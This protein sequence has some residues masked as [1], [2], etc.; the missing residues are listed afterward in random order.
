MCKCN[1]A[2]F[3]AEN[4]ANQLRRFVRQGAGRLA[5]SRKRIAAAKSSG[6]N[7][8]TAGQ[9]GLELLFSLGF[10]RT[11]QRKPQFSQPS[12]ILWERLMCSSPRCGMHLTTVCG[13]QRGPG[14]EGGQA[15]DLV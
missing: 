9:V 15:H 13:S 2:K 5:C 12:L 4:A 3:A 14:G 8:S 1:I 6:R 10:D 11:R 7:L